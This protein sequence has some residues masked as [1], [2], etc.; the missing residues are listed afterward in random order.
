MS[1]SGQALE[2]S[3]SHDAF[4]DVGSQCHGDVTCRALAAAFGP[5]VVQVAHLILQDPHVEHES[6]VHQQPCMSD[7]AAQLLGCGLLPS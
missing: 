4:C 5:A 1:A 6:S 2:A 3:C 7:M